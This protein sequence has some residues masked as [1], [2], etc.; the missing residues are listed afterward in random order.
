MIQVLPTIDRNEFVLLERLLNKQKI[1]CQ[2]AGNR[3]GFAKFRAMT[4]GLTKYRCDRFISCCK[5]ND[6]YPALFEELFRIGE[7]Y[8]PIPFTSVY[9]NNNVIC[10]RHLDRGNAGL[11]CIIS[12]GDYTGCNLVIEDK[13]YNA[14]N[15]PIVFDGT[16]LEHYNTDD[17]VGNKYSLVFFNICN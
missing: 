14:K 4:L 1:P 17:L 5:S 6:K 10:P 12:L 13:I 3:Y 15:T 16:K 8:C 11:S 2:Q 9:V 7:K